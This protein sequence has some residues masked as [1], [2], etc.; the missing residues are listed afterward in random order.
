MNSQKIAALQQ[1]FDILSLESKTEIIEGLGAQ[2]QLEIAQ[3]RK[4]SYRLLDDLHQ[5]LRKDDTQLDVPS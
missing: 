5:H 4:L 2:K 3:D 1:F